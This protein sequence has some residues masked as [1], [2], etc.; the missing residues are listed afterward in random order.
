MSGKFWQLLFNMYQTIRFA[1]G[2]I[3]WIVSLG[4]T[5]H[6]LEARH[7]GIEVADWTVDR[8]I[9]VRFP[10]TLTACG[11]SDGK[12]NDIFG[13]PDA[14]VGVGSSLYRPLAAHDVGC[15][16]AGQNLETGQLSRHYIAKISLN[17]TLNHN[18]PTNQ[19]VRN[20]LHSDRSCNVLL[21][22]ISHW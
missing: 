7:G 1:G 17:V 15:P 18:Q 2:T 5:S 16:T 13:R 20:V 22:C 9:R 4:K 3:L 11:P 21:T 8:K 14:R 10:R 19:Q 6:K 12:V